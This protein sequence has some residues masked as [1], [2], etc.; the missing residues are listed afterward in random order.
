MNLV[1][2]LMGARSL[3]WGNVDSGR[4]ES[5][6]DDLVQGTG[7]VGDCSSVGEAVVV[8]VMVSVHGIDMDIMSVEKGVLLHWC[9]A[10]R[11]VVDH[12]EDYVIVS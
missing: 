8:G 9:G 4:E 3:R 5:L 7:G 11:D 6:E 2:E 1:K 10:R 12:V